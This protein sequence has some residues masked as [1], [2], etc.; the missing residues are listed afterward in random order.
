[1]NVWVREYYKQAHHILVHT[2]LQKQEMLTMPMFKD[3]DI[4]VFPLGIDTHLFKPAPKPDSATLNLLYVGRITDL[5][6]IHIAIEL[7][8]FLKQQGQQA[9]FLKII[10]PISSSAYKKELDILIVQNQL[11]KQI[12]FEG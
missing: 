7:V 1:D 5:K 8:A 12:T 11:E 4:R 9:V 10:G 2:Q 3:L 6:R